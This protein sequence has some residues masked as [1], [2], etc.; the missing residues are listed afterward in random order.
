MSL[1]D[2]DRFAM[3]AS[4]SAADFPAEAAVEAADAIDTTDSTDAGFDGAAELEAAAFED[5]ADDAEPTMTF[6]DLGLPDDIVRVLA[7]RGSPP[8]SRSRP[9]PCRTR[10]PAGRARPRPY[11]LRQDPEP[12]AC[13]CWPASP[14]GRAPSP[15]TRAA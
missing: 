9:R 6:G 8:R 7:K 15:S 3:P 5:D 13:R 12:S 2:D 4:G 11:R 14:D 1:V 10:W